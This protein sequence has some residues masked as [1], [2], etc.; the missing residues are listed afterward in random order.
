M[1]SAPAKTPWKPHHTSRWD[2]F[3][4]GKGWKL[5]VECIT[6]YPDPLHYR[7]T[8]PSTSSGPTNDLSARATSHFG[9][10]LSKRQCDAHKTFFLGINPTFVPM[11]V[12]NLGQCCRDPANRLCGQRDGRRIQWRL[13]ARHKCQPLRQSEESQLERFCANFKSRNECI[14]WGL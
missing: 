11:E 6:T 8:P 5:G 7:S 9:K 1:I 4:F 12:F 2:R 3:S 10:S 13:P 14:L